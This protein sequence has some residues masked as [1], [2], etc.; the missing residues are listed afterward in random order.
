MKI[1]EICHTDVVC[2]DQNAMAEEA[3]K[4]MEKSR[5]GSLIAIEQSSRKP[6]GIITDRD[7]VTKVVAA[8]NDPKNTKV[9]EFMSSDL[10]T[11]NQ[12]TDI[13]EIINVM[14]EKGIRRV[15]IVD[16]ENKLCGIVSLDDLCLMVD[17]E[18]DNIADII[19]K[20]ISKKQPVH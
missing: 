15:P 2:I 5:I 4:L 10:Y 12:N 9:S 18:Q 20:Q 1:S 19:R 16:N 8:G 3:A 13:A 14:K 7:I 11:E 6:I 17:K